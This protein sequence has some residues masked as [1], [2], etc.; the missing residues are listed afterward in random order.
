MVRI[1]RG[2]SSISTSRTQALEPRLVPRRSILPLLHTVSWKN[3][4]SGYEATLAVGTRL[5]WSGYEATPQS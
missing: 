2:I 4:R 3:R 1:L 5:P